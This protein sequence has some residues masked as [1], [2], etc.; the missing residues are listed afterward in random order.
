MSDLKDVVDALKGGRKKYLLLKLNDK[1][2]GI[3][4][5]YVENVVRVPKITRVPKSQDYFKGVINLRGDVIA[6]MSL[7]LR[8]KQKDD[9]FTDDSRIVIINAGREGY[10][11]ILVDQ[12]NGMA[13][14]PEE[15]IE[16]GCEEDC[17]DSFIFGKGKY[18]DE[19]I[20]LLDTDA[21]IREKEYNKY[22]GSEW[23]NLH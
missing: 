2:Y 19:L 10:V 21:V 3:E 8:M 9:V 16:P 5:R 12:V 7:C 14:L 20:F 11:G 22:G 23:E 1:Q 18:E 13:E 17:A 15:D 6:V 4:I